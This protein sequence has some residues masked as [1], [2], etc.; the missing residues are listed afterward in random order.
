[1]KLR[2]AATGIVALSVLVSSCSGPYG[3]P[4]QDLADHIALE[5]G[6]SKATTTAG[7]AWLA[8]SYGADVLVAETSGPD[9]A[10]S[11]HESTR[12]VIGLEGLERSFLTESEVYVCWEYEFNGRFQNGNERTVDC[13]TTE[14]P[15]VPEVTVPRLDPSSLTLVTTIADELAGERTVTI[16]AVR[17]ALERSFA[18][19]PAA[20]IDVTE[21][22]DV[23]AATVSAG[24]SCVMV[25]FTDPPEVWVPQ[26]A[27][28]FNENGLG[29]CWASDAARGDYQEPSS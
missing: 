29:G 25:R 13:P 20:T 3:D 4:T 1:M 8:S 21:S 28:A 16:D 22:P 2:G 27:D 12:L 14:Q 19:Q 18:D 24:R 23:I 10:R 26:S 6:N 11:P 9:L 15:D 7:V 5:I 17:S